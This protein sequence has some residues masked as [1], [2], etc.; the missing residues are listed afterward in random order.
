MFGHRKRTHYF[1]LS[2]FWIRPQNPFTVEAVRIVGHARRSARRAIVQPTITSKL[3][4]RLHFA[5][6][7]IHVCRD[8]ANGFQKLGSVDQQPKLFRCTV[9]LEQLGRAQRGEVIA[10]CR[11]VLSITGAADSA[12]TPRISGIV[13]SR[14]VHH[15]DQ[16]RGLSDLDAVTKIWPRL[17]KVRRAMR[18]YA[19]SVRELFRIGK[20]ISNLS[21]RSLSLQYSYQI[22]SKVN[23]E[24]A[25]LKIY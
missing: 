25:L 22:N 24:A 18:D 13:L 20:R 6:R 4:P 3:D 10:K 12:K 8:L 5:G 9:V 7:I 2:T 14:V 21:E 17:K 11:V 19:L 23:I 1:C 15:L 16:W